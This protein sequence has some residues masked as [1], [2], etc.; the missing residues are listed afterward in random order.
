MPLLAVKG[1]NVQQHSFCCCEEFLPLLA[2]TQGALRI[3]FDM[4]MQLL[5]YFS[6]PCI[7][8]SFKRS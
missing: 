6:H 2:H 3:V 8:G 4:S 7:T 5:E 1:G